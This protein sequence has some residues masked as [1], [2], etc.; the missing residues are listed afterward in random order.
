MRVA[1]VE[2]DYSQAQLLS[3]YLEQFSKENGFS[4]YCQIFSDGSEF[5][6]ASLGKWDLILLDIEMP[7]LDGLSTARHIREQNEDVL[8]IFI[9]QMAQYAIN[10]YEVGALDYIL[11]PVTYPVF[12]VKFRRAQQIIQKRQPKSIAVTSGGVTMQLSL[13][14][15]HYIEINN[16]TLTYHTVNGSYSATGSK[17]IRALENELFQYGLFRCNQCYLVNL[18][19]VT[20]I[21]KDTILLRD[22]TQL[23]ISRSRRK[24]FLQALSSYWGGDQGGAT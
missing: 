1:I 16:H 20:Q 7:K 12:S 2:D 19:H 8:I 13:D 10:G 22:G 11:K 17:T 21:E 18:K 5:P 9:T 24:E 6:A 14:Q 4:I 15:L 23:T 3:E